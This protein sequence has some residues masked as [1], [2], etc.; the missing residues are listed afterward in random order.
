[1]N[2]YKYT[3]PAWNYTTSESID[4]ESMM[5]WFSISNITILHSYKYNTVSP[6]YPLIL[7]YIE[8]FNSM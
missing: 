6:D 8:W 2:S 3:K 5:L 1:M 7:I 4:L